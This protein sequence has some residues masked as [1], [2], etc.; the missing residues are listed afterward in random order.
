MTTTAYLRIVGQ[1][2]G[3]ITGSVTS[4]PHQ[5]TIEVI[6]TSHEIVS[7]RDAA[8]GQAT[9]KRTHKPFV[10]TKEIDRASPLLYKVLIENETITTWELQFWRSGEKGA[11]KPYYSIQ[12]SNASVSN[13]TFSLADDRNPN[14]SK[15]KA[16]EAVAFT[17]QKITWIW[18]DG[19]ITAEDDWEAHVT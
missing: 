13:I 12:L 2:Q 14:L 8:T 10:I 18:V 4:A 16:Y 9:G 17:Y 19:A 15:K 5:G 6:A 11:E 1:R 7:P 3:Q